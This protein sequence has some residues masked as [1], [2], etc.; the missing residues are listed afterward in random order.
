M[1]E[2]IENN[3]AFASIRNLYLRHQKIIFWMLAFIVI[4]I[5][6][7]LINY[8][9]EKRSDE[10][11]AKIYNSW[12]DQETETENGQNL[13]QELLNELVTSYPKSGYSKIALMQY[14]S[15]SAKE[16]KLEKSLSNFLML[17]EL[18]EGFGG[19]KLFN[20]IARINSARILYALEDYERALETLEKYSSSS[21]AY[22]HE[23]LG[24]ILSK[25]NKLDLAKMQYE[26][27]KENY[28][29]ETSISLVSMK[30][31]NIA[32]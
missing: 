29:D 22:I 6:I 24:D 7:L 15:F 20:K 18:T 12:V 27:A 4:L 14:A 5:S 23:L 16:G 21:D 28:N 2:I 32:L 8:Q 11:S 10:N 19:N 25:Q 9:I 3:K 31:S 26:L 30:I 1:N 17:V 13:S